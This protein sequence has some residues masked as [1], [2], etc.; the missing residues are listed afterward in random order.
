MTNTAPITD[1]VG[2]KIEHVSPYYMNE[3][4]VAEVKFLTDRVEIVFESGCFTQ[5]KLK[6][7][8]TLL[9]RQELFYKDMTYGGMSQIVFA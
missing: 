5:M 7:F 8:E 6:D 1:L 9:Q 4:T 3:E 2:T